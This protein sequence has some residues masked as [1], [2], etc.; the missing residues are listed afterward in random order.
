MQL[1]EK[2]CNLESMTLVHV[3][4]YDDIDHGVIWAVEVG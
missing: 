4:C 1:S 3:N 2:S